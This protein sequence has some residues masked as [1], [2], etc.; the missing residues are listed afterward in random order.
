MA[1]PQPASD[2]PICLVI[3]DPLRCSRLESVLTEVGYIV[4]PFQSAQELWQNFE[5]RHPRYI[6]ADRRF[7]D[8]FSGLD[9]CRAVRQKFLLPYVYIHILGSA[10]S[11]HEMDEALDAGASDYSVK[12]ISPP[13]LRARVRVGLRWLE[14]IDS[15]TMPSEP[16]TA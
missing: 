6:I 8:G 2:V 11:T 16:R 7:A 5:W 12:P 4:L 15:I 14:Y 3:G 1:T 13:Q 9:L 10:Q